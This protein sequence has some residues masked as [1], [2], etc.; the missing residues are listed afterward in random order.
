M[1]DLVMSPDAGSVAVAKNMTAATQ[2]DARFAVR[3]E[4][5]FIPNTSSGMRSAL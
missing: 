4:M 1:L 3:A 5:S 2:A